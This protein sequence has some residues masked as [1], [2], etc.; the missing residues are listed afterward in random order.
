MT[1]D[2]FRLVPPAAVAFSG[3]RT[4]AYMLRRILDAHGDPWGVECEY[5]DEPAE[6][7]LCHAD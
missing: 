7:C 5:F 2:P 4:S 1:G 3:G 6:P